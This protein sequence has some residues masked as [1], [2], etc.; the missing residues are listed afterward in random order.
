MVLDCLLWVDYG[1]LEL[2]VLKI[3]QAKEISNTVSPI[4]RVPFRFQLI[5]LKNKKGRPNIKKRN[6]H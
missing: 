6:I 4:K 3:D 1:L 2:V 5:K